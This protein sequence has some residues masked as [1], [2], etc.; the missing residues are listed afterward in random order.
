LAGTKYRIQRSNN[1]RGKAVTSIRDDT[2]SPKL[3]KTES[4]AEVSSKSL[5]I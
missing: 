5:V 4:S 1:N 3:T 2:P